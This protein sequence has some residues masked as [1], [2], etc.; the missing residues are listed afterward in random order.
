[1]MYKDISAVVEMEYAEEKEHTQMKNQEAL[2]MG[3]I[4]RYLVQE[5]MIKPEE[6][7]RFLDLLESER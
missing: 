2:L 5:N 1:M 3:Q 4:A 6:Q 7:T